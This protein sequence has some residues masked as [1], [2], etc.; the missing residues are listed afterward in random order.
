MCNFICTEKFIEYEDKKIYGRVYSPQVDSK[1][2]IVIFSHGYNGTSDSFDLYGEFLASNG[3]AAYCFDFCGGSVNSRSSL[4]TT[5]MTV[6]TEINDLKAVI[7]NI[8]DWINIDKNNIFLFGESQGGFVTALTVEDYIEEIR[9]VILLYPAFCIPDNWTE[10]YKD[11][12]SIPKEVP[13]WGMTLGEEFIKAIYDF[14]IKKHIGKYENNILIL[15]GDKDVI[16]PEKYSLDI[17][18]EYKNS[19]VV[20]FPGEEHGFSEEGSK[21]VMNMVVKFV[22]ENHKK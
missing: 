8:K 2:P 10:K 11:I 20:I 12:Y 15:H 14:N 13:F 21:E 16:V 3:I 18:K 19:N 22:N 17:A 1:V 5:E 7:E 6:F 9:G 4:K